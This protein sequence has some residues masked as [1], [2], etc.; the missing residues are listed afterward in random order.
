MAVNRAAARLGSAGT[1]VCG[2]WGWGWGWKRSWPEE[3][4]LPRHAG[5][6]RLLLKA[7]ASHRSGKRC[8]VVALGWP[9]VEISSPAWISSSIYCMIVELVVKIVY[10]VAPS[11]PSPRPYPAC[12]P[13]RRQGCRVPSRAP[14]QINPSSFSFSFDRPPPPRPRVQSYPPSHRHNPVPPPPLPR[15]CCSAAKP[16][17]ARVT[18]AKSPRKFAPP[19]VLLALLDTPPMHDA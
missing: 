13:A 5:D 2:F 15:C 4:L 9:I 3:R 6:I 16:S 8:L 11:H 12:T 17:S 1:S 10:I 14:R 7:R 19:A 18:P